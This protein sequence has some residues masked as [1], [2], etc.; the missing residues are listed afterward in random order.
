MAIISNARRNRSCERDR[1]TYRFTRFYFYHQDG[2][3]QKFEQIMD[4]ENHEVAVKML[5]DQLIELQILSSYDEITGV[6]HRVVHGGETYGDSVVI[7]EKVMDRIA[8]LAEFAP[9]HNPA[10]LMGIKAFKR[11]YLTF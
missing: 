9:L 2:D 6:G 1:R 5:L 11:F 3:N 4:I 7:D 10:N 8:E